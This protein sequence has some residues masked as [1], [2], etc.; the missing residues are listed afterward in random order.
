ML[1]IVRLGYVLIKFVY[2]KIGK[3]VHLY[4]KILDMCYGVIYL[5]VWSHMLPLLFIDCADN[6]FWS[7]LILIEFCFKSALL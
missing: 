2:K 4:T 7:I 1:I 3:N 6:C 5:G